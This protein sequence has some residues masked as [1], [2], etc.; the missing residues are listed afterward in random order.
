MGCI[1]ERIF[2]SYQPDACLRI[3]KYDNDGRFEGQERGGDRR[4]KYGARRIRS[5]LRLGAG[6]RMSCI[7]AV[8]RR[9]PRAEEVKHAKEEGIE[10]HVLTAPT[11]FLSDGKGWSPEHAASR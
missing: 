7:V 9:C 11:E 6:R 10:F 2:D 8:K 3:P 5:A 1:G 4:R